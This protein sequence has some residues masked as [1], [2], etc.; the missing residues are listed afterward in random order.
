MPPP[1]NVI[2]YNVVEN[3]HIPNH[4]DLE[5]DVIVRWDVPVA[6]LLDFNPDRLRISWM[7]ISWGWGWDWC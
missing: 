1:L 6:E 2:D 3:A 4:D 7:E 5:A